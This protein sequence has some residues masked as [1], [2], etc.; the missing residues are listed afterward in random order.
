MILA[1]CAVGGSCIVFS[2]PFVRHLAWLGDEGVLLHAAQRI[3]A[4][5]VPYRD[6]FEVLPPGGFAIMTAWMASFGESFLS[7][8][9][10]AI[11]VITLCT[12]LAF[13]I[14]HK[15]T[16]AIWIP[17]LLSVLWSLSVVKDWTAVNHH[18]ITTAFVLGAAMLLFKH[19]MSEQFRAV[20]PLLTGFLVGAASMVTSSRGAAA[21]AVI[22]LILATT[23][24]SQRSAVISFL[25]GLVVIPLLLTIQLAWHGALW[26][27]LQDFVV[28]AVTGY[29]GIQWVLFGTGAG[30]EQ[31]GLVLLYPLC[32]VVIAI[33]LWTFRLQVL[34]DPVFRAS[35]LIALMGWGTSFPRPDTTHLAVTA[36]LALPCMSGCLVRLSSKFGRFVEA[37]VLGMFAL[38]ILSLGHLW[39]WRAASVTR[40]PEIATARGVVQM[41]SADRASAS[42]V[43]HALAD[44]PRED[45]IFFYP[46]DPMLPYL[47]DRRGVGSLDILVPGYTTKAQYSKVCGEVLRD[48]RWVVFDRNAADPEALQHAFPALKDAS[49]PEKRS[50]ELILGNAFAPVELVADAYIVLRRRELAF[51]FIQCDELYN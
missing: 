18:L 13:W 2:A 42:A 47:A 31:V 30:P 29:S 28:F 34:Q 14:G 51:P 1:C 3:I 25:V 5:E 23:P 48:A 17:A 39:L 24:K 35:A 4:G 38:A 27:G 50:L 6:F 10:F 49:P 19:L 22:L 8:R 37:A 16:K 20:W 41:A 46:Y 11:I 40:E 45:A 7:V 33:V 21:A 26:N 32:L 36:P 9:I 12:V 43:F 15:T 44:I